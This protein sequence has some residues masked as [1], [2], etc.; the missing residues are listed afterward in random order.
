MVVQEVYQQ[1]FMDGLAENPLGAHVCERI[2]GPA[3]DTMF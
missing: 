3:P 1:V 2:D